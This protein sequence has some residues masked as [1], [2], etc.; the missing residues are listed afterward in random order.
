MKR[1]KYISFCILLTLAACN[2]Q[3]NKTSSE[4][5]PPQYDSPGN[6]NPKTEVASIPDTPKKVGYKS[7]FPKGTWK[8]YP[9]IVRS[10]WGV[11]SSKDEVVSIMGRP[12]LIEPHKDGYEVWFYGKLEITFWNTVVDAVYREDLCPKY[13]SYEALLTSD[14]PIERRFGAKLL[15]GA[16]KKYKL[17]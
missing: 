11:G 4:S 2:D 13:A 3:N 1:F 15:E 17:P 6:G 8:S 5:L 10:I 7:V 12:E 14:D 9:Q 16:V